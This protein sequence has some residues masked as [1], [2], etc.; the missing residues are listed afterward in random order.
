MNQPDTTGPTYPPGVDWQNVNACDYCQRRGCEYR[1]DEPVVWRV[2]TSLLLC[3]L[4]AWEMY[5]MLGWTTA[6]PDTPGQAQMESG[7]V[8]K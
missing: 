4:G 1:S 3:G 8:T 7:E 6:A 5:E 2:G